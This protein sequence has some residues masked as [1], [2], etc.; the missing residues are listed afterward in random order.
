MIDIINI[1]VKNEKLNNKNNKIL[2]SGIFF[3]NKLI[4]FI[5]CKN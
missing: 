2:I 5:I 1:V 4:L 3:L